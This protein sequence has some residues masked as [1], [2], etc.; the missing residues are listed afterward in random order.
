MPVFRIF[1]F[2]RDFSSE[3]NCIVHFTI[4]LASITATQLCHCS[5]EVVIA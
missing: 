3:N 4:H 1:L 2:I 5:M